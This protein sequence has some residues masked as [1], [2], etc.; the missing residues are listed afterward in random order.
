M[1]F[2]DRSSKWI[3]AV[4]SRV[5]L[6]FLINLIAVHSYRR[7]V[8]SMSGDLNDL[9]IKVNTGLCTCSRVFLLLG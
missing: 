9:Q 7:N 1:G 8:V 6:I 2:S 5:S 3:A 4:L